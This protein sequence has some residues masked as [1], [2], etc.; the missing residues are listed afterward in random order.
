MEE[1]KWTKSSEGTP[2]GATVSPVLANLYL[3]YG[4]P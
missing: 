3:H 4:V 2:Q 1:G